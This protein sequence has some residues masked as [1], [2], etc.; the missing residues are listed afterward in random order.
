MYEKFSHGTGYEFYYRNNYLLM[1]WGWDGEGDD[2][3]YSI[4]PNWSINGYN[5]KYNAKILHNFRQE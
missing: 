2:G 4:S 1:N 3:H 5:L